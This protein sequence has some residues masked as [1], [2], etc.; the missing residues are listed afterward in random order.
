MPKIAERGK[1]ILEVEAEERRR[2]FI[3]DTVQ[4]VPG[5]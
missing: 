2:T 3:G 1:N 5:A 4:L